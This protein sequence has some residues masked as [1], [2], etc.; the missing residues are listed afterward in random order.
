MM[1]VYHG[2]YTKIEHIDFSKCHP[3][4]DFGRGFYVTKF[5]QQAQTWAVRKGREHHTTGVV[6]EFK[7]TDGDYAEHICKI[8]RFAGY[9]EEW[10][11]FVVMNRNKDNYKPAHSYDII[12]GPVADD[13][14]QNK[15][16][17][18][19]A[20]KIPK[21][22]FL[23]MLSREEETHQ[24]CFCTLIALHTLERI[25][26]T[27][28]R[29]IINIAEPLLEALMLDR[30][31]D[32]MAAVDIFFTSNTLALLADKETMLYKKSWQEIYEMLKQEI[33]QSRNE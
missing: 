24:I 6:S 23:E 28:R 31:I 13:K 1:K 15:I 8:K 21:A 10:L 12:E 29:P 14:I 18:Y 33:P 7:F 16:T 17:E 19:L 32:E 3:D 5:L 2:S 26:T 4:R 30:N 20:G 9:N 25:D 11:D 22:H 27:P